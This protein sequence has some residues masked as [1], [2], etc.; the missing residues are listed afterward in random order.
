ELVLMDAAEHAIAEYGLLVLA[1]PPLALVDED[2]LDH[3]A[4]WETA[5]LLALRPRL[6]ALHEL[7]AP[8]LHPATSAVLGDD[9][10]RATPGQGES[11]LIL[12]TERL[13]VGVEALLHHGG[14]DVLRELYARRR[15]A[16]QQY[17]D[18]YFRGSWEEAILDW[19]GEKV[20]VKS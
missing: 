9:P 6:V 4:H 16:Y 1:V 17:V 11:A 3:A 13:A 8:P 18:R 20:R 15:A 5:L 14:P 2:M 19:W 7:D 12:A 10:R